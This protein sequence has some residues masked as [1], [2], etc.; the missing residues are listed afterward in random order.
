MKSYKIISIFAQYCSLK[1]LQGSLSM[2]R[3]GD[4]KNVPG[5]LKKAKFKPTHRLK[6]DV[7]LAASPAAKTEA[8]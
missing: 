2:A 5:V 4:V 8:D 1:A 7:D 6:R 3:K